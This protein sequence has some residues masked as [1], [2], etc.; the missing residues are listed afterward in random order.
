MESST[1]GEGDDMLYAGNASNG[2]GFCASRQKPSFL[3]FCIFPSL[4][5][6]INLVILAAVLRKSQKLMRQSHVYVHVSSTLIGN[7]LFSVL[8]LFQVLYRYNLLLLI[9][10]VDQWRNT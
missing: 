4:A 3:I 10:Y 8:A 2:V 9:L 7:V 6:L 5:V 1:S